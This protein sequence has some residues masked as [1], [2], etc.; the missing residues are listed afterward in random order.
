[1]AR[2]SWV[3]WAAAFVTALGPSL[4]D[5]IGSLFGNDNTWRYAWTS[6][7]QCLGNRIHELIEYPQSVITDL[8]VFWYGGAPL[9]V[10]AFAGRQLSVRSGHSLLGGIIARSAAV[11]LLLLLLPEL[12]LIT[13]DL[14]LGPECADAWGPPDLVNWQA[15]MDLYCLAPPLLVLLAVRSP[16][17]EFVRRG[18]LARTTVAVLTVTATL[19]LAAK[20]APPPRV[21]SAYELDCA[22]FGDVTARGPSQGEKDFLC[23]VRG[24]SLGH[25]WSVTEWNEVADRDVLAQG[26][27]LCGLAVQ[28]GGDVGARAVREAP[29]TSLTGVLASLCPEVA[30][31]Q[32]ADAQQEKAENDAYVARKERACAAHPAHRPKIGPVRQKRATMWT[33]FWTIDGWEDGYEGTVPEM[34]ENLVGSERGALSIWAADEIGHACVT[35]ESYTRRPP[36]ELKGWE[37]VVEVGYE[38]PNGS[39]ELVDG[40]GKRL[41]GLTSAGPGS[42][43]VRVHLRGRELVTQVVDAPAGAVQLLIMIFPGKEKKPTVYR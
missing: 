34:V 6:W 32:E 2:R 12:L 3:L 39:L 4:C 17:R 21:S 30:R 11:A 29:Q 16:R 33:E 5:W 7:D 27:H 38:S 13:F 22:G 19:L 31:K 14:A 10:L 42:Y 8:P 18:P 15:G 25:R 35:V 23:D 41:T 24:Y 9:I 40:D 20:S 28:H 43:R 36:M 37:E 26:R 1:M